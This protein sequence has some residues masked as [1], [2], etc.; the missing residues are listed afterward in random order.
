MESTS[1]FWFE[2][3]IPDKQNKHRIANKRTHQV[4]PTFDLVSDER[5]LSGNRTEQEVLAKFIKAL[6]QRQI[7]PDDLFNLCDVNNDGTISTDELISFIP[8][9]NIG[10][11][12]QDTQ[13]LMDL[14]DADNSGKLT[15]LE[16]SRHVRQAFVEDQ[17][18]SGSELSAIVEKMESSGP[19]IIDSFKHLKPSRSGKLSIA[20][21]KRFLNKWYPSLSR[22]EEIS[23]ILGC[24]ID[25]NSFL[26]LA[27]LINFLTSLASRNFTPNL[28]QT[29]RA[30]G[31][32][33]QRQGLSSSA[34][35]AKHHIPSELDIEEFSKVAQLFNLSREQSAQ[36]FKSLDGNSLNVVDLQDLV[37]MMD[38]YRE[39]ISPTVEQ[40][41]SQDLS[42]IGQRESE[43][44]SRSLAPVYEAIL[45]NESSAD[46]SRDQINESHGSR[47]DSANQS[48]SELGQA[49]LKTVSMFPETLTT[50][51]IF[52]NT[53]LTT[54]MD[55]RMFSR[56]VMPVLQINGL[57]AQQLFSQLDEGSL[58]KVF[59][60]QLYTYIDCI[61]SMFE[62]GDLIYEFPELPY[63]STQG[64]ICASMMQS[65]A[66]KLDANTQPTIKAWTAD[67]EA[68]LNQ[69]QFNGLLLGLSMFD[70]KQLFEAHD[71][72]LNKV[73]KFYHFLAVIDSYRKT[74][75][76]SGVIIINEPDDQ[77]DMAIAFDKIRSFIAGSNP[78][79]RPMTAKYIF[80]KIDA[81]G[82]GLITMKELERVFEI[83]QV[84]SN[85]EKKL[86]LNTFF[87][88]PDSKVDYQK[89]IESVNK[90]P[91][92]LRLTESVK[93][94]RAIQGLEHQLADF[95]QGSIDQALLKLKLY[96]QDNLNRPRDLHGAF[97][98]MD[99]DGSGALSEEEFIV[100]INR[101]KLGLTGKQMTELCKLADRNRDG[102]IQYQD[103]IDFIY[104]YS[105]ADN[106]GSDEG[107]SSKQVLH[108][109]MT[110][111]GNLIND[112]ENYIIEPETD[113]F[114]VYNPR[115]TT[116]LN[117]EQAALK[118]C[119]E[120]ISETS[121]FKDPDFGPEEKGGATA[122]Y[123]NGQPPSANFPPPSELQWI[124]PKEW[125]EDAVFFSNDISSNDVIQ[126]SLGDCW[127]IGAL[128]VLAIRD[129]LIRG[130][131]E[132]L[133]NPEQVTK[134][135]IFGLSKGVYPPIFHPFSAKGLY[136][137]K[138]FKNGQWRFVIV[139][140]RL[141][142]YHEE[143]YEPALV[144]GR[145]KEPQEMWVSIIEKAYAKLHG[146]YEALGGGLIDDGLVDMTGFVAE[147]VKVSGK[148]GVLDGPLETERDKAET[149]WKKIIDFRKEGTLMGCSIDGQGVESDV[150]V[151]GEMTGLLARHAYS[152]ID[153][154]EIKNPRAKKDGRHRLIRLRNPW[155]Q[156]EW[157]GKWS[158]K[159]PEME[160][161]LELIKRV[162]NRLEEEE[163]FDPENSEDGSF[164]MCFKDWRTLYN[165][166]YACVDFTDEWSGIR[167]K[168]AWT[169]ATSG[170]VPN[171]QDKAMGESWGRNPQFIMDLVSRT[172]LFISLQQEDG[173][174]IRNLAF[175][176]EGYIKTACFSVMR[177]VKSENGLSFFDS[178]RIIKLSVLKLHR[179]VSLRITLDPGRYAIVPATMNPGEIG[180]FFL[181]IYFNC[182]KKKVGFFKRG[183]P[184]NRGEVIQEEE[185]ALTEDIS[186]EVIQEM[187]S[188]IGYLKS[189]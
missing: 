81:D 64:H 26:D 61:R 101:L 90:I 48:F 3:E 57:Q 120:L 181:S 42:G 60:Y 127:F 29:L 149:L 72:L 117:T 141:P 46:N 56:L 136:V 130:S 140:E 105:F 18:E 98:K 182:D 58:G 129:E 87:P 2:M 126:G 95:P 107:S 118:R 134:D 165:N 188:L 7:D 66:N 132:N 135:T 51:A 150:V 174:C 153:A 186:E 44:Q 159:S 74:L 122:L 185:E 148:G 68:N 89:F 36:V 91:E 108:R 133:V 125:L 179:E 33:V 73:V 43:E 170:G 164:L 121:V 40:H 176:Y 189:V 128:S 119:L 161:N 177:L 102:T 166:L 11:D 99:E 143:G 93:S 34:F 41:S 173:R 111:T 50:K 31:V 14:L 12:S 137:L 62:N 146:C 5:D 110:M 94:P 167:F 54:A 175:P 24:N 96:A 45:V 147:K 30:M 178:S 139:D 184:N 28:Q 144:F 23:L 114:K 113:Y 20:R 65:L 8:R 6:T 97:Q 17:R 112:I 168:D 59:A 123:W 183:E 151:N 37:D 155:G 76:L 157:Q 39:D 115:W 71:I 9:L 156:R 69:D 187:R 138:F 171:K 16:Y 49:I 35:F 70:K 152:L 86:L 131:V 109:A 169:L 172:D 88:T 180:N 19:K 75:I 142:C 22:D 80:G 47:P 25:P 83:M 158:D 52:S 4:L 163:R 21:F 27:D 82:D 1:I 63:K 162:I 100:A 84:L 106:L 145:N 92:P 53:P 160:A 85:A 77:A 38:T 55:M 104:S 15:R 67:P 78:K 10:L 79:H 116:I 32:F 124:S 13:V 154:L 103:F